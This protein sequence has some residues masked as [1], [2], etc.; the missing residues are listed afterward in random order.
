MRPARAH[1][2][3]TI[4]VICIVISTFALAIMPASLSAQDLQLKWHLLTTPGS[5]PGKNDIT[6]PSEVN[7]IAIGSDGRTFYSVDIPWVDANTGGKA[8]YKSADGGVSWSDTIGKYLFESMSVPDQANFRVWNIAVAPDDGNFIAAVTNGSA[9]NLPGNIWISR[10]GGSTWH[11]SLC[12]ASPGISA[13]AVSPMVG[14]N[15]DIAAGTRT[16]TGNGNIWVLNV[17]RL[18]NWSSQKLTGDI[19]SLKFSPD[20]AGDNTL[21][22]LFSN[23]LGTYLT[24]GVRDIS[25]NVT[26]WAAIYRNGPVEITTKSPGGSP[27]ANQI[28]S[29]GLELPAGYTNQIAFTRRYFIC[30]DSPVGSCGIFRL[31]DCTCFQLMTSSNSRRISS[32]AYCGNLTSGKLLAGEVLGNTCSASVMTWFTDA[33]FTC[34]IPCWYPSI[35]P[36]T[37]GAG[38][39]NCSGPSYGNAAVFWSPDGSIAYAGTAATGNLSG[40]TNWMSPY[41]TGRML[42]ESAFSKSNNNGR[43]WA[44]LSLIDTC[45][46]ALD[47]IAPAPDCS[48]I[49]LASINSNPG[50]SGFDSVWASKSTPPGYAWERVLCSLTTSDNCTSPQSNTAILRLA[51]DKPDGQ[52]LVWSAPGTRLVKWSADYGDSWNNVFPVFPVQDIAFADSKTLFI[53]N[54]DGGVQRFGSGGAGWVSQS[55]ISSGIDPAYSIATAYTGMTPDNDEGTV[56]VG[57]TGSGASDVAYSQD[58]GNNFKQIV[59]LLPV[60]DNTMVAASSSFSGN[61]GDG[62]IL[63]INS[64]GMFAYSIYTTGSNPWEEWWGGA[65]YPD[66]VTGMAISRNYSQYFCTAATWGS[67]TPYI[68]YSSAYSGLD[69]AVSLGAANL[70]TTRFRTCG[71]LLLEQPTITY[72]IDQ[73]PFNPPA[74]GVWYYIDDLLWTGPRPVS[75]VNHFTV[76]CDPVTG[77]AGQVDLKW[78]PRSLS[79]GYDIYIAKDIDFYMT[80]AK[81]GD[82]YS[83]PYY[84]PPDLEH[85]ALYIPPGGGAVTDSNGNSWN[86]PPLEAGHSYYWKVM[87]QNVATGDAI[88]S[89]WSWRE[90]YDIRPGYKVTTAYAGS[91]STYTTNTRQA[92][93]TD[94]STILD[95]KTDQIPGEFMLA[96]NTALNQWRWIAIFTGI[97]LIVAAITLT[98]IFRNRRLL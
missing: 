68:R 81:I 32:I 85:P 34:S 10:D 62:Y 96:W 97:I 80:V 54:P 98:I 35:K 44:Q 39:D 67:A 84:T 19:M 52:V 57:G 1:I 38:T 22:A 11:N 13:I 93:I 60:R 15:R 2:Y 16:G 95:S 8:I 43:T 53:L 72:A 50:C 40:G 4:V 9:S 69:P 63:A 83:G 74:G 33:P 64:G 89:P 87:V 14:G 20:Y 42:D 27:T 75:P 48:T 55:V 7:G 5:L 45:I 18:S 78:L 88:K 36:P 73:R 94:W 70:P 47:D 49:Y 59:R 91:Q 76:S 26:D 23:M 92:S 82:D 77:R 90:S 56:L 51:G 25:A 41:L 6:S 31:D 71:G 21:V 58:N 61:G 29:A 12:P 37:G 66:P 28:V 17:Q 79:K 24:A 86:V 30:I 65:A 3:P 46:N